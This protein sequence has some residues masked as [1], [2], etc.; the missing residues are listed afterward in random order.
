[1]RYDLLEKIEEED[2]IEIYDLY[3]IN[4]DELEYSGEIKKHEVIKQE[5]IKPWYISYNEYGTVEYEDLLFLINN[6]ENPLEMIPGL[7]LNIPTFQDIQK[8]VSKFNR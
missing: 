4:W 2:D 3:E 7:K 6:V 8:F 1:M 5:T